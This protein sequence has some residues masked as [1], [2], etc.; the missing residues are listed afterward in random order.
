MSAAVS[1]SLLTG[2]DIEDAILS[3]KSKKL[4]AEKLC[5]GL[6]MRERNKLGQIVFR[7]SIYSIYQYKRI[8]ISH[9]L[10]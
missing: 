5:M 10:T 1:E 8:H 7:H 3:D 9:P 4:C 6:Y 2:E